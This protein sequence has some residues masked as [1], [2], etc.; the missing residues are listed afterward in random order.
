MAEEA[1]KELW[2]KGNG[3][4][5]G[6]SLSLSLRWALKALGPN[7]CVVAPASCTNVV[8]GLYPR[9]A[10]G[11]PFTNMVFAGGAA[12][13]SGIKAAMRARGHGETNVLVWAGDGGTFDIGIQALS[14][15]AE[16]GDDVIYVCYDNEAYM[17]TGTQRSGGTPFGAITTTTPAGK[18]EHKKDLMAIM[19]GHHLDYLATACS[20]YPLDLYE[21]LLKAKRHRGLKFIHLLAPCPPGWRFQP[22]HAPK[23]GK[24]A[25]QT[26]MWILYEI[27]HGRMQLTGPSKRL[28][29]SDAKPKRLSEYLEIQGRFRRAQGEIYQELERWV[30]G[31]WQAVRDQLASQA[32]HAAAEEG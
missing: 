3:T 10:S 19:A 12:A 27:E 28:A 22:R 32:A 16:R 13:A 8:V 1:R 29:E 4:C 2:L 20:A 7:T 9:S 17:N 30:E 25:V 24:L 15:A 11:V 14:G 6:C 23:V 21:K 31:N 26:G 5:P 18:K